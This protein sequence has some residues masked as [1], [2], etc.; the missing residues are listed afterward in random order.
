M[1]MSH[2]AKKQRSRVGIILR[3]REN[4]S[5][6]F[7]VQE[8]LSPLAGAVCATGYHRC[9]LLDVRPCSD[10]IRASLFI[11]TAGIEHFTRNR[12]AV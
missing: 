3:D 12:W 1:L 9:V 6:T 11:Y 4:T 7:T 5:G 8:N 2:S 10:S